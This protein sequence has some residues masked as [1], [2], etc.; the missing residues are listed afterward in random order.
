[1]LAYTRGDLAI[2]ASMRFDHHSL[3]L[4]NPTAGLD[5]DGIDFDASAVSGAASVSYDFEV[6]EDL[7]VTPEIGINVSKTNIDKF[8]IAGGT[9]IL[10]DLWSAIGHVGV[11]ARTHHPGVADRVFVIPFASATL[12]HEFI[13]S[14]EA[15]LDHR[16][17]GDRGRIEPGGD[18]RAGGHR[19][20]RGSARRRRGRSSD[21]VRRR[22]LR[23]SG[24]RAHRRRHGN[25]VRPR[26]V[27][28]DAP[29]DC[30]SGLGHAPGAAMVPGQISPEETMHDRHAAVDAAEG[31]RRRQ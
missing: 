31:A 14:A 10:D 18:V 21:P 27:L 4:T 16:R 6:R 25:R 8:D 22:P 26:P 2:Q 13:D 9:V 24:R 28:I 30:F 23:P 17:H 12:Y 5:A 15:K 29:P 19:G 11:T 1:M 3:D 7:T 20:Q